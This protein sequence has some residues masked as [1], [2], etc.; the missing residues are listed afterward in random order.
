MKINK[1]PAEF[2]NSNI[3]NS[4]FGKQKLY[5]RKRKKTIKFFFF[6]HFKTNENFYVNLKK[7]KLIDFC[8]GTE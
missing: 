8:V 4:L 2:A 5:K 6:L 3:D 1:M 7:K